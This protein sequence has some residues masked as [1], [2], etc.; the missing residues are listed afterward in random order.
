MADKVGLNGESIA[1]LD[2][3]SFIKP[4]AKYRENCWA[5]TWKFAHNKSIRPALISYSVQKKDLGGIGYCGKT[6]NDATSRES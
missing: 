6:F 1:H 5:P 2:E 4:D 3:D